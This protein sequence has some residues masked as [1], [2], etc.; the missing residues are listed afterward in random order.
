M[1]ESR[2][3]KPSR[4]PRTGATAAARPPRTASR[5]I[6]PLMCACWVLG[7]LWIVTYYVAGDRIG[8]L[9]SLGNWNLLIGMGFIILGF[10]F[11]VRWE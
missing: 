6:A 8:F 11:A 4:Y 2:S 9:E 3:R 10:V 5:W 1:P 7:L